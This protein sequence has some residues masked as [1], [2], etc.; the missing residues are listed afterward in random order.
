MDKNK[1]ILFIIRTS[2]DENVSFKNY[3]RQKGF[4]KAFPIIFKSI[5]IKHYEIF[6]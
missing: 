3:L 5:L 2:M 4:L 1:K 6:T